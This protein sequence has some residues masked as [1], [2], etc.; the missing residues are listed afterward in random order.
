ME[1]F[2][3]FFSTE[4]MLD[5][6]KKLGDQNKVDEGAF[7]MHLAKIH[8]FI[9]RDLDY[10]I[11]TIRFDPS[12]WLIKPSSPW[13]NSWTRFLLASRFISTRPK[14]STAAVFSTIFPPIVVMI[15]HAG[16]L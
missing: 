12:Q 8:F 14:I 15:N 10:L 6:K 7:C 2:I 5:C 9:S 3:E 1:E 11:L 4:E 16:D 13:V